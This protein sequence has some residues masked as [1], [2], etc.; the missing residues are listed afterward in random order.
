MRPGRCCNISRITQ[1]KKETSFANIHSLNSFLFFIF[2]QGP[3]DAPTNIRLS[4]LRL[5]NKLH[6]KLQLLDFSTIQTSSDALNNDIIHD[7]NN[8]NS[9]D[10]NKPSSHFLVTMFIKWDPPTYPNGRILASALYLTTNMKQS[11]RKWTER[12]VNGG[13]TEAGL[14]RLKPST[15]YFVKITSRNQHGRSPSSNIIAFYT[16]NGMDFSV[17][18]I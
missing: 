14:L 5:T 2:F 6:T 3:K 9:N 1:I 13:S 11:T 16:P 12:S 17:F 4:K 8:D 7:Q 18:I 15:L 10:N